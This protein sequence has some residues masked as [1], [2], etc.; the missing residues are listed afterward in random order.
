[1]LHQYGFSPACKY[2]V[3]ARACKMTDDDC[4]YEIDAEDD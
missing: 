2:C 3:Y 4:V 1:M